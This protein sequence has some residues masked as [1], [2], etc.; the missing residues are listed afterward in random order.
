MDCP[1]ILHPALLTFLFTLF[2]LP[3]QASAQALPGDPTRPPDASSMPT[4]NGTGVSMPN[5]ARVKIIKIPVK[6]K[7]KASALID[8]QM[9]RLGENLG[10]TRLVGVSE[11]GL[12]LEGEEGKSPLPLI[13]NIQK[14]PVSANK[15]RNK[16]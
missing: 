5:E 14:E 6:S 2:L 12:I 9:V 8:G 4:D 1:V 3:L 15:R 10:D 16:E 7:T 13:E 11:N